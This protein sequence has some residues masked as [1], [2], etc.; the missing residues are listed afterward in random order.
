[1][2]RV[3]QTGFEGH[4]DATESAG[5]AHNSRPQQKYGGPGSSRHRGL[6]QLGVIRHSGR[7]QRYFRV[8]RIIA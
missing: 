8:A 7:V 4:P 6:R 2:M 1:M 5:P 3:T